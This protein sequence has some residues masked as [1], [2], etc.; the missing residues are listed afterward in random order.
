MQTSLRQSDRVPHQ[1]DRYL[2]FLVRDGD[3]VELDENNEDPITYIDVMQRSDSEKWLKAMK[4]KM[5]SMK[6]NDV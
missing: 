1:S 4:S 6:I 3:L 2:G 5:E